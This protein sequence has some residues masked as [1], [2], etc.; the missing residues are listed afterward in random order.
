[1]TDDRAF[2]I[3]TSLMWNDSWMLVLGLG[4]GLVLGLEISRTS[5]NVKFWKDWN[6]RKSK[7]SVSINFYICDL[8]PALHIMS[9]GTILESR[10][11][12][13]L[14]YLSEH[15]Y[16]DPLFV[17]LYCPWNITSSATSS[18]VM[19]F[20]QR[21]SFEKF[22]FAYNSHL[23]IG[24][25]ITLMTCPPSSLHRLADWT[26]ATHCSS[27][28]TTTCS[29]GYRAFRMT[30]ARLVTGTGRRQHI[31]PV[32]RQLH[33]ADSGRRTL[34]SSD[35]AT[36]VVRRTNSTFGDRSFADAGA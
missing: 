25:L 8:C 1:M 2:S 6:Y 19:K 32:L 10:T 18:P 35:T 33:I 20:Q 12:R 14:R 27:A 9:T 22:F 7:Y 17:R 24:F 29:N 11:I 3:T 34:R 31:T 13:I 4:F 16:I 15:R 26:T 23:W 5:K 28:S 21:T 30:A 36:F